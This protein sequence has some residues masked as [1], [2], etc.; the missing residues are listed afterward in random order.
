[1]TNDLF[2]YAR[3][4]DPDSAHEGARTVPSGEL[5]L[6][7]LDALKRMGDRGGTAEEVADHLGIDLQSITPR[8]KP[9]IEMKM[10]YR[11]IVG[12]SDKGNPRYRTRPG[13]SGV[14]RNIHWHKDHVNQ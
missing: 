9:L 6:K 2:A 8:F 3:R 14:G 1:M 5:M 4:T 10:I 7:V 11:E 13:K 12:Y